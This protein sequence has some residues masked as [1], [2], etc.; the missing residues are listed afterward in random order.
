[1]FYGDPERSVATGSFRVASSSLS[2]LRARW[3]G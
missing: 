1:M 3:F 2:A